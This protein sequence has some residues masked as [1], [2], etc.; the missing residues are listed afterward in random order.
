MVT[1]VP[2]LLGVKVH[3]II[4]SFRHLYVSKGIT[5]VF[6]DLVTFLRFMQILFT[7]F[8][9]VLQLIPWF[10]EINKQ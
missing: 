1:I 4:F 7:S 8:S 9:K 10:T 2:E 3:W 5:Q 6:V